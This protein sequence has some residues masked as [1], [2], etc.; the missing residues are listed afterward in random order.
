MTINATIIENAAAVTLEASGGAIVNNTIVQADD[1]NYSIFTDGGGRPRGRFVLSFTFATAP[2]ERAVISLY[3]RQLDVSGTN[4][5]EIPE[6]TRPDTWVGNFIVNNVTTTQY[7]V[8]TPDE[9]LPWNAA[10]YL[11]NNG[12]GQTIS[13]GWAL[14]VEPYTYAPA[15]A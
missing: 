8:L 15:T 7:A 13:A 5:A 3:A 4:D 6:T 14:T 12:T 10:Y 11:H 1:A 9:E 2:T